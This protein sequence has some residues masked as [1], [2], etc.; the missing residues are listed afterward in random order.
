LLA[1]GVAADKSAAAAVMNTSTAAAVGLT[2]TTRRRVPV[3][4]TA[5]FVSVVM[6]GVTVLLAAPPTA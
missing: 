3:A 5:V 6:N 2:F 1:T 4:G